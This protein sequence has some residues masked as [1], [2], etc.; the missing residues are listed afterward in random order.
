M[1]A[2][3]TV[4]TAGAGMSRPANKASTIA[5]TT[6]APERKAISIGHNTENRS[7][8]I[9]LQH[10]ACI[11]TSLHQRFVTTAMKKRPRILRGRSGDESAAH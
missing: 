7:K 11:A 2:E 5:I 3:S 4:E 6:H 10:A 9:A 1:F 8:Q